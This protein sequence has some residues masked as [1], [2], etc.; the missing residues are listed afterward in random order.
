MTEVAMSHAAT[1]RIR[2][3]YIVIVRGF[4]FKKLRWRIR[5]SDSQCSKGILSY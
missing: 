4:L 2:L 3:K 1:Q 5:R